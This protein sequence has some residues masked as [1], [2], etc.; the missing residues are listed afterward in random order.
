DAMRKI[1]AQIKKTMDPSARHVFIGH[2]FVT[3]YGQ[4]EENTS[5]SE[6][7]L[8]V[9][10]AEYVNSSYFEC[11]SYTALGHLHQ[12]HKVINDHVRY[13]GSILKYSISEENH[14]KGFLHI[15]LAESGEVT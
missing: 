4:A 9:G 15:D 7:P 8:Q 6:R 3:P 12:A 1:I 5:E 14:N 11:F 2:A 10:G 13:A